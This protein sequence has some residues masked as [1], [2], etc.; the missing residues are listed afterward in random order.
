MKNSFLV[1]SVLAG[2][3]LL[4]SFAGKDPKNVSSSMVADAAD[5]SNMQ[6]DDLTKVTVF[7]DIR[8]FDQRMQPVTWFA[9]A[10]ALT[11]DGLLVTNRHA[12]P[13]DNRY[14]QSIRAVFHSGTESQFECPAKVVFVHPD[15]DLA[16]L[17]CQLGDRSVHWLA[18]N[19][20]QPPK[21]QSPLVFAGFPLGHKLSVDQKSA[22]SVSIR[23]G[24]VSG[25]RKD[26][27]FR[28]QWIDLDSGA[29]GGNSGGPVV[30][31]NGSLI[32]VLTRAK[33]EFS[34]CIPA[35]YVREALGL[36][37]INAQTQFKNDTV[38]L[39]VQ[40]GLSNFRLAEVYVKTL[41][42]AA[43][44]ELTKSKS[45]DRFHGQISLPDGYGNLSPVLL[46]LSACTSGGQLLERIIR[47]DKQND[48]EPVPVRVSIVQGHVASRSGRGIP[49]DFD[50]PDPFVRF[51]VNNIQKHQ[52]LPTMD[53]DQFRLRT[54]VDCLQG[55]RIR[56]EFL[57]QDINHHDFID[58]V[59]F[60]AEPNRALNANESALIETAI[61]LLYTSPSPRDRTRSRMPSSA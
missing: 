53:S 61:C 25:F 14:A 54:I 9:S 31:Q 30:D 49:F 13:G 50:S 32:G 23:S 6:S 1:L 11:N 35:G 18:T 12:T 29:I 2:T 26:R 55:D 4:A 36:K 47:V 20:E 52:S 19:T 24:N 17:Q 10:I 28:L 5:A 40:S 44:V 37:A 48:A 56:I 59:E 21:E 41:D 34:Q 60:I 46:H 45:A 42:G 22:P 16:L 27:D 33:A 8:G 57:D 7:L 43:V 38:Q 51:S 39:T 3:A 58:Q 15:H